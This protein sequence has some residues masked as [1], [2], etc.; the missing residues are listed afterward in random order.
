MH[1][2]VFVVVLIVVGLVTVV[3]WLLVVTLHLFIIV[4]ILVIIVILVTELLLIILHLII[5]IEIEAA[6]EVLEVCFFSI[7]ETV[8]EHLEVFVELFMH[9]YQLIDTLV[10]YLTNQVVL[11]QVFHGTAI[12]FFVHFDSFYPIEFIDCRFVEISFLDQSECVN[13]IEQFFQKSIE[14][15]LLFG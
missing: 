4:N 5:H 15:F 9:F 8:L 6:A 3:A 11:I 10:I 12:I 7:L 13:I 1:A 2:Y 14:V